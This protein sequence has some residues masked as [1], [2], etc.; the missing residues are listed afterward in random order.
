MKNLLVILCLALVFGAC[1]GPEGPAG[2]DGADGSRNVL[3][4]DITA[5]ASNWSIGGNI[6][7]NSVYWDAISND[8][9]SKGGVLLLYQKIAGTYAALPR[10]YV[11]SNNN[12]V[13]I[14]YTYCDN[15]IQ[16]LMSK[17][18]TTNWGTMGD[19]ECR[20][21]LISGEKYISLSKRKNITNYYELM[22]VLEKE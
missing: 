2:K 16:I 4:R 13:S 18:S 20:A 3:I 10:Q 8:F 5:Y 17:E 21:V 6:A 12:W 11:L 14:S 15:Y 7:T 1:E 9:L 19:V 22:R